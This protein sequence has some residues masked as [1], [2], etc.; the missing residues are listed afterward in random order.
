MRIKTL[1]SPANHLCGLAKESRQRAKRFR[2]RVFERRG[3][4]EAGLVI[5]CRCSIQYTACPPHRI[6]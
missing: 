2:V 3:T 4:R 6:T 1:E 5:A